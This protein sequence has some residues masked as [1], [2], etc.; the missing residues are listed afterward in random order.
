MRAAALPLLAALALGLTACGGDD[1][2]AAGGDAVTVDLAEQNRSGQSGT[3]TLT[4]A[5]GRTTKVVIELDEGRADPQPAHIHAGS[6]ANLDPQPKYPLAGVVDGR[7]ETTVQ[8]SLEELT[9][10]GAAIN[11]HKSEAEVQSYIACGDIGEADDAAEPASTEP[12]YGY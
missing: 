7:S 6:C 1:G 8:A 5:G 12:D 9:G 2:E 4:A 10:G 3:A 11:V